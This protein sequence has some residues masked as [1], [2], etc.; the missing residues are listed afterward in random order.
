MA[1]IP[2]RVPISGNYVVFLPGSKAMKLRQ[3]VPL[4]LG[5]A[6]RLAA[7]YSDLEFYIAL[8]PTLTPQELASYGGT[9]AGECLIAP[10]GTAVKIYQHF[11]ATDLFLG[12]KLCVTTVGANTAQLAALAVP[13]IVL[14]PTNQWDVM[15]A[16]DGLG[17]ILSNLPA[18]GRGISTLINRAVVHQIKKRG[19][20][21]SWANIYANQPI[22]PEYIEYLTPE[23]V[24]A[25]IQDLLDH[26]PQLDRL[27]QD[28]EKFFPRSQAGAKLVQTIEQLLN[29]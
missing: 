23:I 25:Y 6:D 21:L 9:L 16:W 13:M 24:T 29:S 3:G 12:A 19:R 7:I 15:R 18:I 11:P 4:V 28:L 27:R 1:D 8:A 14:V 17:G 2:D 10:R 26:P 5:V 20:F 22:V